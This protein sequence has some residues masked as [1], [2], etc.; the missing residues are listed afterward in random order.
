MAL[1]ANIWTRKRGGSLLLTKK[2]E[3]VKKNERGEV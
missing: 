3:N 2:R 1:T